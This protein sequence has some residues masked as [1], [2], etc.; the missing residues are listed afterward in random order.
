[1]KELIDKKELVKVGVET[2]HTNN[3][4]VIGAQIVKFKYK[5]KYLYQPWILNDQN[6]FMHD[7]VAY[8]DIEVARQSIDNYNVN[9]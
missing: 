4:N 6:N 3:P 2:Y 1:M 7:I 9:N 8:W 5:D